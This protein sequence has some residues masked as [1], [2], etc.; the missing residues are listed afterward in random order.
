MSGSTED[1]ASAYE[2]FGFWFRRSFDGKCIEFPGQRTWRVGRKLTE[3]DRI[4][5]YYDEQ[6]YQET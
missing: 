4:Q 6:H 2:D 1:D 3:K 5:S